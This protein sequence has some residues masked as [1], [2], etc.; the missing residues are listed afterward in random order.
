M[1]GTAKGGGSSADVGG[2]FTGCGDRVVGE[3][4]EC[5]GSDIQGATCLGLGYES[6][7]LGCTED[8]SFDVQGCQPVPNGMVLVPSGWFEMGS[9]AYAD[10]LPVRQVMVSTFWIDRTEVTAA[11]YQECVSESACSLP[12]VNSNYGVPGREDHPIDGV[13]WIHAMEYCGWVDGAVKRLPTEAEWE[14]TARGVGGQIYPW[15]DLPGPG[16]SHLVM[17]DDA[18]VAGCGNDSTWPVGSKPEGA[19]PYGALD[20]A[21]NVAEWVDDWY[22]NYDPKDTVNPTGPARGVFPFI[23][24]LRGGAWS[25]STPD[26]FR[27]ATRQEW[28]INGELWTGFRCAQ[29]PPPI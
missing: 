8:C 16:C 26:A 20:M 7:L 12:W 10:E 13:D 25:D 2:P 15:G 28:L 24:V 4:E 17:E 3:G 9:N 23:K 22:A 19:S 14:K 18:G 6:G 21:G 5:D 1:S 11:D 27:A 29:T